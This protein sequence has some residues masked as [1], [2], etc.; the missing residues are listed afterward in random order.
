MNFKLKNELFLFITE[1]SYY[2]PALYLTKVLFNWSIFKNLISKEFVFRMLFH[3]LLKSI[4]D[5]Q[6]V[7]IIWYANI[8]E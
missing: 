4:H 3:L 6:L 7:A 5:S 2:D 8:Y 1:A